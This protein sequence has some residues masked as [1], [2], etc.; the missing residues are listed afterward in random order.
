[1]NAAILSFLSVFLVA[2]GNE[3]SIVDEGAVLAHIDFSHADRV[4][5]GGQERVDFVWR[6]GDRSYPMSGVR[7]SGKGGELAFSLPPVS[8]NLLTLELREFRTAPGQSPAYVVEVDGTPV[9][10]RCRKYDG[11]GPASTFIDLPERDDPAPLRVRA[12]N[13]A[14]WPLHLSEAYLYRDI[15]Q[16]VRDRGMAIPMR[17]GCTVPW[18]HISAEHLR[19]VKDRLPTGPDLLP[20]YTIPTVPH[21]F[22]SAEDL[23]NRL[24]VFLDASAK[25]QLPVELQFITW[26][27][28]TP[29]G[30]DGRGGRWLDPEYQQVTYDPATGDYGLT[31]PNRWSNVPWL[32][33]RHPR[34]NAFK[35]KRFNIAG[36]VLREVWDKW[37]ATRSDPFPV[38]SIVLDNEPTYWAAGM[39]NSSMTLQA[40][41]NPAMV[42]AA[43]EEGL[44]LDPADGLSEAERLFLQR[45]ILAYNRVMASGFQEG[46][47]NCAL[48]DSVFSHTYQK[49]FGFD[50]PS[51]AFSVGVL[52]NVRFG[53]EWFFKT[54]E[55]IR[56]MDLVRELG[57]PAGINVE[58]GS[59]T[60]AAREV[61][62]AYA[63]GCSRLS[64]FNA[65]EELLR[66]TKTQVNQK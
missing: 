64:L 12:V 24:E 26:W 34:F 9:A 16:F 2:T 52:T 56:H 27:A 55:E 7:L 46:L 18:S 51:E 50:N 41:F 43:K 31:V 15:E 11:D 60:A 8:G 22:W 48:R 59:L 33:M 62:F 21:A 6:I 4:I 32:T 39:P 53:G 10:F 38:F 49:G 58:V 61:P 13:R 14:P 37:H 35:S 30:M 57:V 66:N 63:T 25:A 20:M 54:A 42:A 45:T 28:G 47:G 44:T 19:A 5:Y 29:M 1:M 36:R 17:L 65:S 3:A 40:D 23:R